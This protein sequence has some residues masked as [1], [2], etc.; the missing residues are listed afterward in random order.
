MAF[1]AHMAVVRKPRLEQMIREKHEMSQHTANPKLRVAIRLALT[2]GT[3]AA[4][5]GTA[6]AQTAPATAANAAPS[7][8]LQEVVVTGSR[9]A[10]PNQTSISPVT[11]VSATD[12]Q[13]T[14]VTRVEDLLNQLPQVFADQNSN[15]SNATDGTASVNLRGLA[16][17]RTLVL[18][19]GNRLGPGDPLT[20]G[21]SDINMIPVEMIDSIEVLTGGASSVYGAD[22]V[23]GVVNFKL[24][25]H[26]EGVK[27]VADAGIYQHNNVDVEGVEE[28][29]AAQ[30]YP[31]APSSVWQGAQRS[32]AFIA[33]LNSADGN[34]NATVYATY[35]NALSVLQSQYSYSACSLNSGFLGTAGGP[36]QSGGING[37][38]ACG[39]SLT[40]YP[41]TLYNLAQNNPNYPG[42]IYTIGPN[43][44]LS[45]TPQLFNYGALNYFQRPDERYT[46]GAFLHYEFNEHATVYS[47][48]MF[49]DDDTVGLIAPSGDF[50]NNGPFNCSNP[51]LSAAE[52]G[53]FQCT[54]APGALT[55]PNV[56]ILR[57]DVEGG[58]RINEVEH[59]DFHQIVGVKGAIDN[60]WSYDL[61]WQ[62]SLVNLLARGDNY[63][64]ITKL[65]NALNVTGTAANP[66]CVVGPPCVPYNIFSPGQV[67]QAM[68]D[69]LYT[70][71]IKT[72][73]VS[74]QDVVLNFT[75]D[76]GKYGVQSPM[77]DSGLAINVG[78]EYRD[79]RVQN[80]PDEE[81]QTGD[82]A[83][84]GGSTPVVG[85]GV[86]ARE[87]FMEARM[88][89]ITDKFLADQLN[90][91]TGYRYSTYDL[92]F[93]TN[94]WKVGL[95]WQPVHDVRLRAS[96]S[97]AVRAPNVAELY[98][99]AAIG[100][101]GTYSS[102][103]CAGAHPAYSQAQCANTGVTA[104]QYGTV[105][106]NPA[107]QYNGLLGGNPDLKPET[108][109][110]SSF[111][112]GF[113]PSFL[114][115]FR[116]QI[117]YYDIHIEDVIQQ[118]GGGVILQQCATAGL[119]CNLIHR[120]S[121]GTLWASQ[122]QAYILDTLVNVGSLEEK[123][124]D[125]DIAYRF[126]MGDLG[127]LTSA[128]TGTYINAYDVTPIQLNPG[129]G[130]NCA[131]FYGPTCS[132][133]VSG[134]GT[135]VFRWRHRFTTTWSTPWSGLDVTAAWRFYDSVKFEGLSSNPNLMTP[136]GATIA[137]GGISNTDAVLSSRS[138]FDLTAALKIADKVTLR[139]GV[140]NLFDKNPPL[141]GATYGPGPPTVNGNTFPGVYDALG[142]YI[143][144][145]AIVQF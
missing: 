84:T 89:L 30:G 37:K 123:G 38:Y 21:Q 70:V 105:A 103:P 41:G 106:S 94:T 139:L 136:G 133:S 112:V 74:Q 130:F 53:L 73:R 137:N 33:G 31:Q 7:E 110:T 69:Y 16:A 44:T 45:T 128:L 43:G 140:N 78:A 20:A 66:V 2:G 13:Q 25:D 49:M 11:F 99:P 101:D 82:L 122:S 1:S 48:T 109:L 47:Q 83:G 126:D 71:G 121:N 35:R 8:Q 117:D 58:D 138:Y 135:P 116:A 12:I 5:F 28:A 76:L 145:E 64:S 15:V 93:K 129:T 120:D 60:V 81:L 77:A 107:G 144:G 32:L 111:G 90:F 26:F 42:G 124:V 134:A 10:V 131:G 29:I 100:L 92:G 127:K 59:M 6:N 132:S 4:S 36:T 56:L 51:F 96:F 85:G 63:F 61:S 79:E 95:D 72:G 87:G 88:P 115:G 17:K 55:N 19:N 18:V 102:D 39:G 68:L 104:A 108:A 75:G 27:L 113:T 65:N 86:I 46:A 23:A 91:E 50:G 24:N 40:S 119:L 141:V 114:P 54:N 97:R 3:L 67:T 57:R 9:I 22:A 52:F 98:T 142:R 125:V 62:Y 118:I 80:N 14:G 143:F 34:G